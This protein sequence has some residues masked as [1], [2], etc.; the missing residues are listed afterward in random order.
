MIEFTNNNSDNVSNIPDI[1]P[2]TIMRIQQFA[3]SGSSYTVVY[4]PRSYDY[5]TCI[6]D[7]G[8]LVVI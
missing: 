7:I 6:I 8:S 3:G 2:V 1:E 5:H 4:L